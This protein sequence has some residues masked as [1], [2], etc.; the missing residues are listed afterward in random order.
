MTI[1]RFFMALVI[2]Y[3]LAFVVGYQYVGAISSR[4]YIFAPISFAKLWDTLKHVWPI[5]FV[6]AFGGLAYNMRVMRGNLLDVLRQPYI[7]AARAKGL[8][9]HQVVLKHAVP[10]ALHPLVMYQGVAMPYMLSGELEVAIVLGIPTIG[11]LMLDSLYRSDVW[12]TTTIFLWLSAVLVVANLLADIA[13]GLHR[14]A[15]PPG[16]RHMNA[17]LDDRLGPGPARCPSLAS[18]LAPPAGEPPPREPADALIAD[19]AAPASRAIKSQTYVRLVWRRF[20]RNTMGMIGAALVAL[21][22]LVTIFADFL[23]P[24]SPVARNPDAIYSPPQALHF[25]SDEGFHLIPFTNPVATEID[26]QT[27]AAVIKVDTET[28][29]QPEFL[30]HGWSYRLFGLQLDRHLLAA[31]AGCPWNVIGTD[32]DGRDVLSRLLVGSQL[33]M[34]IALHRGHSGRSC[35]AR[36][37]A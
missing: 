33:T 25:F 1:P 2:L 16:R 30:G 19:A 6:A 13:L 27:F 28:R 11:P 22:L 7:E 37:S 5:I 29:C 23:S 3:W 24:Y 4:E 17:I 26:P 9:G 20:R 14:S 10:N 18:A 15:H 35:S 34:A 12:V 31:P 21:L 32:R 8:P 36:W